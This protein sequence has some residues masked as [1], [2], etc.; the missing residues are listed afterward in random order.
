MCR[1]PRMSASID[2]TADVHNCMIVMWSNDRYRRAKT[3]VAPKGKLQ[4]LSWDDDDDDE[5]EQVLLTRLRDE[6][7]SKTT[8]VVRQSYRIFGEWSCL[9]DAREN[10][11]SGE[12]REGGREGGVKSISHSSSSP[13]SI[14]IA[15][16]ILG[17]VVL[18][19][20][21]ENRRVSAYVCVSMCVQEKVDLQ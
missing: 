16:P 13:S 7:C 20:T 18:T 21:T 9:S 3:I 17:S 6:S 15:S 1:M 19:N 4:L 8:C 11:G 12:W 2:N 10:S 5:T 14:I